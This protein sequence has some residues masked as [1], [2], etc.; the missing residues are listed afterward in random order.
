MSNARNNRRYKKITDIRTEPDSTLPDSDQ[1]AQIP[2]EGSVKAFGECPERSI[3][4]FLA[5]I[6][7]TVK[8]QEDSADEWNRVE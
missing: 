2:H 3:T 8:P 7:P 6:Y 1:G 4:F 5:E